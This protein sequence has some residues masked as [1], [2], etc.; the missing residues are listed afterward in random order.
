MGTSFQR[1]EKKT[2]GDASISK[3]KEL[4]PEQ[5]LHPKGWNHT[6]LRV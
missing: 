4:F 3:G 5:D 1:P 6:T 2:I